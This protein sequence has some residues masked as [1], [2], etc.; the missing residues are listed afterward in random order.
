[1]PSFLPDE[2]LSNDENRTLNDIRWTPRQRT[3]LIAWKRR[4][5]TDGRYADERRLLFS[6]NRIEFARWLIEHGVLTDWPNGIEPLTPLSTPL[7]DDT[8][9]LRRVE[10][11]RPTVVPVMGGEAGE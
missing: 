1:M 4:F 8:V 3:M 10:D 5:W 6:K 2:P 11:E 7:A 9:C